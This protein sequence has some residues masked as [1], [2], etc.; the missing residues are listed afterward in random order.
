MLTE[1]AN[2]VIGSSGGQPI[3]V[4]YNFYFSA[5]SLLMLCLVATVITERMIEPR[6]GA[7]EATAMELTATTSG[8]GAEPV[9][10][11]GPQQDDEASA[12]EGRGLRFALFGFLGVLILWF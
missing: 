3:T 12:A 5:V 8:A 9:V 2:E 10:D 11:S 4:V 1:V 7:Y 6:L